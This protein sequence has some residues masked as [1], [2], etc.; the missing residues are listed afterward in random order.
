MSFHRIAALSALVLLRC[1]GEATH[2]AHNTE[3]EN[4]CTVNV[5]PIYPTDGQ[6]DFYYLSPLEFGLSEAD[7]SATVTLADASGA[8]VSGSSALNED[9][10]ELTFTPDAPLSSSTGYVATVSFCDGQST[11][12]VSF[13]T[14]ELGEPLADPGSIVGNTYAIDISSA[15]LEPAALS[16]LLEGA[17]EI[18]SVLLNVTSA[19]A[20]SLEFIGALSDDAG[21]VQD[22]C[23]P[24]LDD[25]PPADFSAQPFFE[26]SAPDGLNL[27][28]AGFD[29]TIAALNINGTFAA[30]GSYFG[31]GTLVGELD[32]RD[33]G[34]IALELGL[35]SDDPDELCSLLGG[36]GVTCQTC[37]SDGEAYCATITAT[38]IVANAN[39]N[40]VVSVEDE[41]CFEG[42][43]DSCTNPECTQASEFAVCE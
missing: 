7:A 1:N 35:E 12:D 37:A 25:F 11:A 22:T 21:E 23:T 17:G 2:T 10:D 5:T 6:A 26:F 27:S 8:A 4:A 39:S 14:S 43:L 16:V 31:G 36:L 41:N 13:S 15:E 42:C 3:E 40:P 28:V 29:I 9:Q 18:P 34:F 33:I 32:A 24:T 38:R 19:D 20:T 30:D